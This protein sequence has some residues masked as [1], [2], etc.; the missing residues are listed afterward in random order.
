MGVKLTNLPVILSSSITDSFVFPVGTTTESDQLS[1]TE[2]QKSF[3][4]LTARTTA[5]ISIVGKTVAS[6]I[7]ISN[8]G[9]VG[10]DKTSPTVTLDVGD[11]GTNGNG[12]VRLN[13]SSAARK[14]A[15]SLQDSAVTWRQTKRASDTDFY[16]E[17]S[18][19]SG[20]TVTGVLNID[21]NGNV[22]I[23]NGSA[24]LSDKFYVSGG[25]A[26]F[27]SGGSGISIVPSLAEIKSTATDDIFAINKSNNND[28]TI[29]NNVLYIDNDASAPK[30][31]I[32]TTSPA[33]VFDA[34]GSGL[35]ARLKNVNS[36]TTSLGITNTVRTGY[37]TVGASAASIGADAFVS[38]N[39]V[40]YRLDTNRLA[41][42]TI[43]PDNK[44]HV[45][46]SADSRLAKLENTAGTTTD[47]FQVNNN[48]AAA[49]VANT[50][51]FGRY[52]GANNVG[53]W[54]VGLYD[55]GAT[56]TYQDVFAFYVDADTSSEANIKAY[57]DRNGNL[58][59]DGGTTTSGQYTQ[60]KHLQ[61]Y[62]SYVDPTSVYFDP[63]TTNNSWPVQNVISVAA[64][65][66]CVMPFA[67]TIEKV[68]IYS[69]YPQATLTALTDPRL[70]I[71]VITPS[72]PGSDNATDFSLCQNDATPSIGVDGL[73]AYKTIAPIQN[74][75]LTFTK[76]QF[77]AGTPSF[78]AGQLVQYRICQG[79][80]S[81][82]S[83]GFVVESC[84]SFTIT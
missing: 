5:G 72:T 35:M 27:Q 63:T 34:V 28:I 71:A 33:Y 10:V 74:Q 62:K 16:I 24:A 1:L 7:T 61:M 6:G 4:G 64:T 40:N 43:S 82:T 17:V 52:D 81:T 14:I 13:A 31:G 50:Y 25:N 23:F 12:Q 79:D 48:S 54:A 65:P 60:G 80:G 32:N 55:D 49:S 11:I 37:L 3:T 20:T 75:V 36:N 57:L 51:S 69:A 44:L 78:N 39:N 83:C 42:G 70:E 76:S 30:V 22:G 21:V 46:S 38:A 73:V 68:M 77:T 9:Y 59:L 45:F 29:G 26:N 84:I 67:G 58:D 8:D 15:F 2:L 18:Q 66:F 19:D 41:V 56:N 53:K 47:V